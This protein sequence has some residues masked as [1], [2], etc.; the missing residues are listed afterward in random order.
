MKYSYLSIF[1]VL[2]EWNGKRVWNVEHP[3]FSALTLGHATQQKA[4]NASE[5]KLNN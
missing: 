1:I 5:K 2:V 4:D 3:A